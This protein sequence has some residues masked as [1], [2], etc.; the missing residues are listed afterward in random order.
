[1]P[2]ED[3]RTQVKRA[4]TRAFLRA[5]REFLYQVKAAFDIGFGDVARSGACAILAMARKG[6]LYVANAG[7]CR[8][9]LGRHK[10]KSRWSSSKACS[11]SDDFEAVALSRDHNAREPEEQAK[12]RTLHPFEENIIR[13]KR[14]DSCYVKGKLQPTRSIGDAY[15]KFSEFNGVPGENRGRYIGP[16]Y[17]P[18]YVSAEPEITVH[19]IEPGRDA[20]VVIASDGVWDMMSN[21]EVVKIVGEAL[22]RDGSFTGASDLVVKKA[23]EVAAAHHMMAITDLQA[24]KAGRTRRDKHDDMTCVIMDLKQA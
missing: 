12:L 16:P 6:D 23:L 1:M 19:S 22:A 11:L 7:D 9:V 3:E 10:H 2:V 20:F 5:E 13:C 14:K 4:L 24:L 8:A 17:T 21:E 18:P 15:L